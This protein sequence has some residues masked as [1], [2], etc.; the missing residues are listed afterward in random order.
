[1]ADTFLSGFILPLSANGF[2]FNN[3]NCPHNRRTYTEH[4]IDEALIN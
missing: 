2:Y 1:V 3:D 4:Y